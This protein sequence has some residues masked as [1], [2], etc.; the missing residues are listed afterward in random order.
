MWQLATGPVPR[1]GGGPAVSPRSGREAQDQPRLAEAGAEA[2][3]PRLDGI[4]ERACTAARVELI[5]TLLVEGGSLASMRRH[6]APLLL[7]RDEKLAEETLA[8]ILITPELPGA[9]DL[10]TSVLRASPLEVVRERIE[11]RLGEP[12]EEDLYWRDDG[13]DEEE[14]GA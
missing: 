4:L 11:R 5:G 2:D 3:D 8:P 14:D 13:D 10:L 7:S 6:V 12:G 1:P 9:G